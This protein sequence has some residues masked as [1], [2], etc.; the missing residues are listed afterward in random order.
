MRVC[1]CV[2]VCVSVCLF[3][4]M[5]TYKDSTLLYLYVVSFFY[6]GIVCNHIHLCIVVSTGMSICLHS[7]F[8]MFLSMYI[9]LCVCVCVCVSVCVC[10]CVCVCVRF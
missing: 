8:P 6:M 2:R 5:F 9:S 10:V 3:A 7:G 4:F 1:V